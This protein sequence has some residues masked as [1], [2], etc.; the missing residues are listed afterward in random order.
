MDSTKITKS[1]VMLNGVNQKFA[2]R[3]DKETHGYIKME[4]DNDKGLIVLS[5]DNLKFF[6][7]GEYVYKLIFSGLKN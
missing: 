2:L 7:N 3:Q 6:P 1:P 5:I 4:T